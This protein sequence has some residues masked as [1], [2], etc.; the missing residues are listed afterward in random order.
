MA[1]P[2]TVP[3]ELEFPANMEGPPR[4]VLAGE[5]DALSARM[6]WPASAIHAYEPHP[7]T[8][9]MLTANV[10]HLAEV[11]CT[12]GAVYPSDNATEALVSRHAGDGEAR[13]SRRWRPPGAPC[14][15]SG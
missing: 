11:S 13:L 14:R 4:A 10:G 2:A 7:D 6:R 12:Q 1:L 9:R 15:G 8:F 3:V 5:Y